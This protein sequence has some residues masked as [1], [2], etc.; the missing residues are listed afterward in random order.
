MNIIIPV[1]GIGKRLR[2][3]TYT[4]PKVLIPVAGKPIIAHILDKTKLLDVNEYT[5]VIGYMGEKIKEYIETRYNFKAKYIQ[6]ENLLG[7]GYALWMALSN[8]SLDEPALI[9]LGDTIVDTDW[10]IIASKD[11][12]LICTVEVEDPR[13]FGVVEFQGEWVID[14]QEKPDEP[15]SNK[16]IAGV[17]YITKPAVL[18]EALDE[19]INSESKT[20]GEFQL[21]DAL[22]IMLDKGEKIST[23]PLKYWY[24]CGKPETLLLSNQMLLEV[25]QN[26]S[27]LEGS[28][29]VPPVFIAEGS[30]INHS[31]IGPHVS[32]GA[33]SVIQ[34]SLIR[35]SIICEG[36]FVKKSTLEK[37]IIG[38]NVKIDRELPSFILGDLSELKRE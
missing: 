9:I 35:D 22:K 23:Y 1:A 17:Y 34:D 5:F 32:I 3:L 13:R 37:S 6:Q 11:N 8:T 19:L 25:E 29:I 30:R 7:L 38:N 14:L 26:V 36:C 31:V 16:I 10:E 2:P 33:K 18:K 12:S 28:V 24:D 15:K 20:R 4:L 27:E 21:T